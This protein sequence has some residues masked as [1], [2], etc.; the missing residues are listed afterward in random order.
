MTAAVSFGLPIKKAIDAQEAMV[1][2][3]KVTNVVRTGGIGMLRGELEN[4]TRTLPFTF[5]EIT[6][7]ATMGARIGMKDADLKSW[8]EVA[9]K[10]ALVLGMNVDEMGDS[11]AKL[12]GAFGVATEDLE[13]MG[14]VINYF[15]DT[16]RVESA[17]LMKSMV[18]MAGATK[19]FG[20][21]VESTAALTTAFAKMGYDAEKAGSI[22]TQML[23][24]LGLVANQANKSMTEA[25]KRI[26]II[27]ATLKKMMRDNPE[28]AL[29]YALEKIKAIP[30]NEQAGALNAIFGQRVQA[31]A[32]QLA[33]K[34]DVVKST[35]AELADKT[36][37][38]GA[39]QKDYVAL[40]GTTK[41]Q[42]K[43]F[44]NSFEQ[45]GI[46]IG[47]AVLPAFTSMIK[48]VTGFFQ[49]VTDFGKEHPKIFAFLTKGAALLTGLAAGAAAVKMT[50]FGVGAA[51]K[52]VGV[53][54]KGL[55][56]IA[57]LN[58][59]TL[60]ITAIAIGAA[61][62]IKHWD[63]VKEFFQNLWQW[64]T[65]KFKAIGEF[66]GN[67]GSKV[68]GFFKNLWPF[69]K[70]SDN[71]KVSTSSEAANKNINA[72]LKLPAN[73]TVANSNNKTLTNNMTFNIS[74]AA[75]SENIA[76]EIAK[77]VKQTSRDA[78]Y[79]APFYVG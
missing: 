59:I 22:V 48:S 12:Q 75:D 43:L 65:E 67:I 21:S 25:A 47:E 66:F 16:S 27:P 77:A 46:A 8:T 64:L 33:S 35:F 57:N 42:M 28:Q 18:N 52:G 19:Q 31:E 61:L 55:A 72:D 53:V 23:P 17:S 9:G 20:F 44:K 73:R 15:G 26:G 30:L 24:K 6:K 41:E 34:V 7:L 76:D 70:S 58:P 32:S 29:I 3:G 74:G 11:I 71:E 40:M 39:M 63:K 54:L 60:A 49:K 36:K 37:I 56:I 50:F 51:I 68:G 38:S 2:L 1:N 62:V 5:Q 10:M 4:L 78:M 69:R 45:L 13:H 14:D 79:D